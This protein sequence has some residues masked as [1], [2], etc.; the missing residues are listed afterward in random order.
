MNVKN[1]YKKRVQPLNVGA[2]LF[3]GFLLLILLNLSRF[4]LDIYYDKIVICGV[5]VGVATILKVVGKT[6]GRQSDSA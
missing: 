6:D 4:N 2:I 5:I 3:F 1:M